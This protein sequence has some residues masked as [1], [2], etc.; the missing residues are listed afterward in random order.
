MINRFAIMDIHGG[1]NTDN[2]VDSA[3]TDTLLDAFKN[4]I[5]TNNLD[6]GAVYWPWVQTSVVQPSD[7][8]Y[9]NISNI[10]DIQAK[11]KEES[12]C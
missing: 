8:N 7:L 5:G 2:L 4:N 9:F 1:G 6:Y 11:I 3:A 10:A 12:C